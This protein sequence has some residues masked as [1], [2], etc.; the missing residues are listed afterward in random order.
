MPIKERKPINSSS[1]FQTYLT[2][3]ELTTDRPPQYSAQDRS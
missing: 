3:E 1:R 2:F